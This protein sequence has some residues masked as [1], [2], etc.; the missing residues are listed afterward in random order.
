MTQPSASSTL[1]TGQTRIAELDSLRGL[2]ALG[3]LGL[4]T[5]HSWFFWAW[6]CVDLFFVLSGY[7]ITTVLLQNVGAPRMLLAFYARRA[8][9]IW[10]VYYMTLAAT[11]AIFLLGGW[12]QSG[13]WPALPSGQWLSLLFVQYLDH[14]GP[15][16]GR[17]Q[18]IWYFAH[19]WSLAVEEQFYLL[20]PLIFLY[21]R[22]RRWVLVL[23]CAAGVVAAIWARGHG[24]YFHLLITRIDG[25]L[26]GMLLAFAATGDRPLLH[27]CPPRTFAYLAILAVAL[28]LPYLLSHGRAA[29]WGPTRQRALEVA[30]FCLLYA[31]A[32]G[33]AIRWSG[34]GALALL[35]NRTLVH[36]GRISFAI[37]MFQVPL[38]Y[39]ALEAQ[40]RGL[41]AAPAAKLAIVASTL[42]LAQLSYLFVERHVLSLKSRFPYG[43]TQAGSL[44]PKPPESAE[45]LRARE[46]TASLPQGARTEAP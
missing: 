32:V 27:R 33:T 40:A 10:P 5:A 44:A 29:L 9:R 4:H 19:S 38:G 36:M 30:G 37:Y 1:T 22:P 11:I 24:A 35:R 39:L 20:W 12:L 43:K 17:L 41:L 2:A 42:I 34:A 25:L 26:L 8:L 46:E 45:A 13:D 31:V 16:P 14:Y 23:V 28:L 18:Y 3:V 6:S 21:L 7:L 15:E